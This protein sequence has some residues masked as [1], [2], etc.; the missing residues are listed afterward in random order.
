VGQAR[1]AASL[2]A[3]AFYF[4]LTTSE[5]IWW[6][7]DSFPTFEACNT[8]RAVVYTASGWAGYGR[9]PQPSK[10][11]CFYKEEP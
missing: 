2:T 8:A 4:I 10:S 5:D 9:T 7:S 11:E 3:L 1:T 6:L